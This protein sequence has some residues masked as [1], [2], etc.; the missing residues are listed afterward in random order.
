MASGHTRH[1]IPDTCDHV[2]LTAPESIEKV[3]Q[4]VIVERKVVLISFAAQMTH[5][6][7]LIAPDDAVHHHGFERSYGGGGRGKGFYYVSIMEFGKRGAY[8][9]MLGSLTAGYVQE[10][11]G[12]KT[13]AC[14]NNVTAF[15]NALGEEDVRAYLA[16]VPMNGD[17]VDHHAVKIG[18]GFLHVD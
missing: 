1:T 16:N 7:I 8:P 15:L 3:R 5:Y 12:L 14:A 9:L 13:T 4:A 10:K 18:S 17:N 11:L 6:P 2:R